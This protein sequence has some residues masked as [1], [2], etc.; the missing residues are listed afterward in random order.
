MA[1]GIDKGKKRKPSYRMIINFT[2]LMFNYLAVR[3][4]N[5]YIVVE[6]M[7]SVCL[8]DVQSRV[9]MSF[10]MGPIPFSPFERFKI[11]NITV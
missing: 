11:V 6:R 9:V 1:V 4:L 7:Q 8:T 3:H 5:M 2:E 10:P